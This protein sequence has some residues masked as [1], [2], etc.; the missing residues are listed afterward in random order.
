L[1][2]ASLCETFDEDAREALS[3]RLLSPDLREREH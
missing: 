3:P 1:Q 2:A